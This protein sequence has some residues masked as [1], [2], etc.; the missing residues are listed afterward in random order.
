MFFTLIK[1]GVWGPCLILIHWAWSRACE[2]AFPTNSQVSLILLVGDYLHLENHCADLF[3]IQPPEKSPKCRELLCFEHHGYPLPSGESSNY[4]A[5]ATTYLCSL[6]LPCGL[7][8]R[9]TPGTAPTLPR[10]CCFPPYPQGWEL[11]MAALV[12]GRSELMS[13]EALRAGTKSSLRLQP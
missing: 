12:A 10:L 9:A 13:A 5:W 6:I 2:F 1:H 7:D 3:S 11:S 8:D 4:S